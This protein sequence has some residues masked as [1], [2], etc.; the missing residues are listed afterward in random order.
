M[1]LDR[2]YNWDQNVEDPKT[3]FLGGQGWYDNSLTVSPNDT[4]ILF[5]GGI[6]IHKVIIGSDDVG[7]GV[8]A[9]NVVSDPSDWI[10]YKNFGG[11]YLGGGFKA[12]SDAEI[13]LDCNISFLG[14]STQKAHR[15]VYD[16]SRHVY[17]DLVDVPF[18]V[19]KTD[20]GVKLNVSFIDEN[21]DGIFNL[22]ENSSEYIHI[23]YTEY[24]GAK[25]GAIGVLD[26]FNVK[27]LYSLLPIMQQ[28]KVWDTENLAA[29][30]IAVDN[31]LLKGKKMT[32]DRK[33]YWYNDIADKQ[34]AHADHHG[35]VIDVNNGNP[36]RLLD[37]SDG[38][39]AMSNDGGN[40]WASPIQG[41][42][43]SQFYSVSKHPAENR[44]IGGTQDNGTWVSEEAPDSDS[45][46]KEV[47]GGDG[48][49]TVWHSRKPNQMIAS[50]YYNRLFRTDDSWV[51]RYG[52]TGDIED[53]GDE[54]GA[55]FIT[56]IASTPDEPDM[57]FIA[58][59][60]GLW[61]SSDF[62]SSW[63]NIT[64]NSSDYGYSG[65]S[66]VQMEISKANPRIVWAGVSM[67]FIGK[68][69]VSSDYGNTF[70][71]VNNFSKYIRR[72]S[73]VVSHPFNDSIVYVLNSS[74]ERAKVIRSLDMGQTWADISGFNGSSSSSN[75]FPDVAVYSLLVMPHNTDE[76][77]AGTEIGL[78]ISNDNGQTWHYSNNGLPAVC[79]WD[80]KIVGDQVVL[81]T[82]GRGV[83]SVNISELNSVPLKPYAISAGVTASNKFIVRYEVK[84]DFDSLQYLFEGDVVGMQTD[85]ATG[86]NDYIYTVTSEES[87]I[88]CQVIGYKDGIVFRSNV[89]YADNYH[90]KDPR[91]RYFNDFEIKQ[92]DFSGE[93]F[94]VSNGFNSNY[95]I[96]SYN[97]YATKKNFSYVLKY[98][99][100]VMEEIE[101]S[102]MTYEDIA[103]V[104]K[105]ESGTVFG[106][107]EFWD[108]VVVEGSKDGMNWLPL[109]DGYDAGYSDKWDTDINSSPTADMYIS[110]TI[111]F[112]DAFTP[113]DTILIRFRL[114]SDPN[115]VGWGWVI[116]NVNIQKDG[117][118]IFNK[119][120]TPNGKLTLSPNPASD[121]INIELDNSET[122]DVTVTVY[123]LNGRLLLNRKFVKHQQKWQQQ[124]PVDD[125][126][127][128][129]KII[130]VYIGDD[131]YSQR[132]IVR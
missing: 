84:S 90:Y 93:G 58:G 42:V 2:G 96:N 3:N 34:Y 50:L 69:N 113:G 103:F 4:N 45:N 10:K 71:A 37:C 128:G 28:G 65:G 21:D 92:N 99:V 94:S 1:S 79:I 91:V 124:L 83:W 22:T 101:S 73:R 100:I 68:L 26:G 122:G 13:V 18:S 6:D 44:Y 33:T 51:H 17:Q 80:M 123:S 30:K 109:A 36:F 7:D 75:G 104:E 119:I 57:L 88:N 43:T 86:I 14:D 55:P 47:L 82:H 107:E 78:F 126:G 89:L 23:H 31:Y 106:D 27:N 102:I 76:I 118:G 39:V 29:M 11:G 9:F 110:H 125:L 64:I 85:V 5:I 129:V 16:G 127:S 52:I 20:G 32:S 81:G 115:T 48:F 25:V 61:K 120:S 35:L 121:Y 116:D 41:Y 105:G 131:H 72:I 63:K 108:Y 95:A 38:G 130:N 98:P 132:I 117:T 74:P 24:T 46:W 40:N 112:Q 56:T 12:N 111:N 77:W 19:T 60:S 70:S 8:K 66:V 62:G 97:P 114:F 53:S 49:G 87:V 54:S 67:N 59:P 15:F